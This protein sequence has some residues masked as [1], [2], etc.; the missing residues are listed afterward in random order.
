MEELCGKGSGWLDVKMKVR[1]EPAMMEGV[2]NCDRFI[3]IASENYF[4]RP[5]CL[6]ELYK[7]RDCGKGVVMVI[8][9][10][11]KHRIGEFMSGCPEDLKGIGGINFIDINRGDA[12]YMKLGIEKIMQA[13]PKKIP[14]DEPTG[15]SAWDSPDCY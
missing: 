9:V 15:A 10:K 4:K 7:A 2:E 12:E 5:F 13:I 11:D 3:G 8:D 14:V 6:K 1:D